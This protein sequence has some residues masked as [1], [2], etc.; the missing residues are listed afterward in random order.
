MPA[1]S[2]A[3]AIGAV[4]T[5]CNQWGSISEILYLYIFKKRYYIFENGALQIDQEKTT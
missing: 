1:C 2:L 3:M 5:G 4:E